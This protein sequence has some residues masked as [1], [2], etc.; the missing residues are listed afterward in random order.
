M[1]RPGLTLLKKDWP[2]FLRAPNGASP[3]FLPYERYGPWAVQRGCSGQ[4]GTA[5]S[6]LGRCCLSEK[7]L[8]GHCTLVTERIEIERC[9]IAG[10]IRCEIKGKRRAGYDILCFSFY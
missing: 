10:N 4:M 8:K 9:E 2:F 3:L 1:V 7:C 5:E 6:V